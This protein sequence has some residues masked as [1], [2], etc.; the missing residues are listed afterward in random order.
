MN[1]VFYLGHINTYHDISNVL[2]TCTQRITKH[3]HKGLLLSE[4]VCVRIPA[5]G[6]DHSGM[7]NELSQLEA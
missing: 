7:R 1:K 6:R 5:V 2:S 4:M 3:D